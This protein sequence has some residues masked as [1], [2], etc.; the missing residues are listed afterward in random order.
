MKQLLFSVIT[1][2]LF[3]TVSGQQNSPKSYMDEGTIV[4]NVYTNDEIGWSIE[5][6][7]GWDL[8]EKSAIDRVNDTGKELIEETIRDEIDVSQLRNLISFRKDLLNIFQSNVQPYDNAENNWS[9]MN[10]LSKEIISQSYLNYGM[11]I[12][13][14]ETSIVKIDNLD[15]ETYM[16][17]IYKP[18]NVRQILMQQQ[19][20][21]RLIGR[22]D[23]MITLTYN[24]E[25]NKKEL[26][27]ALKKSKFKIRNNI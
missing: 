17:T 5:I 26:L 27:Q 21:S 7:T 9:Q 3:S 8:M 23:F 4:N 14:S 6:P 24:S 1:S 11:T 15:F 16:V 2:L 20:I 19:F 25:Q 13:T 12:D 18:D 10:S 22:N